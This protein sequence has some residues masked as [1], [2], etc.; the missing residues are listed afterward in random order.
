MINVTAWNQWASR[1]SP[2]RSDNVFDIVRVVCLCVCVRVRFCVCVLSFRTWSCVLL[3]AQ[4]NDLQIVLFPI[5]T[6][7]CVFQPED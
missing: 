4:N 6:Q 2:K 5:C 1:A 7:P 3:G